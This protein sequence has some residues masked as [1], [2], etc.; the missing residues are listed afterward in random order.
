MPSI[1]DFFDNPCAFSCPNC[2]DDILVTRLADKMKYVISGCFEIGE[3]HQYS[4][5]D[6]VT[7]K[8][9][10]CHKWFKITGCIYDYPDESEI[11]NNLKLLH[12]D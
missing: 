2:G 3:E 1:T 8:C 6:A 12:T 9:S 10:I 7:I 11:I 5:I 4:F